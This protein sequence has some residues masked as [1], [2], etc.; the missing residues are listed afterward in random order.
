MD[1]EVDS[2]FKLKRERA[3][4]R[5]QK[6]W[7]KQRRSWEGLAFSSAIESDRVITGAASLPRGL[8][9][10]LSSG[11]ERRKEGRERRFSEL[12]TD[13][14]FLGGNFKL[15]MKSVPILIIGKD[16]LQQIRQQEVSK[17]WE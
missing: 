17:E 2:S 16:L 5:K 3:E 15:T 14:F 9:S 12:G 11:K 10:S 13:R 7:Q 8:V 4:E 1:V 6:D